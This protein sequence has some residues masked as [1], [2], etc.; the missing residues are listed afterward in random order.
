MSAVYDNTA[1]RRYEMDV[2]GLT[3]LITYEVGPDRITLMHTEV[4]RALSGRGIGSALAR[5]V[6]DD[7]RG[8]GLHVVPRCEF[9]AGFIDR[10]PA[11]ADLL[12]GA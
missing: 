5:G 8:R 2:D 1:R 4:P 12:A 10:N 11:Y 6:L 3:A 7:I 9:M